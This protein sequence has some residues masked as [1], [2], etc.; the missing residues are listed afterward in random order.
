MKRHVLTTIELSHPFDPKIW[1]QYMVNAYYKYCLEK[2]VLPKIHQTAQP[3]YLELIGPISAVNEVKQKYELMSEIGE[4]R[5]LADN[6]ISDLNEQLPTSLNK[7]TKIASDYYN[8]MLS[9]CSDDQTL[10]CRLADRLFDEGYLV[11]MDYSDKPSANIESKTNKTDLIIICFTYSYSHNFHCMTAMTS[12][13]Q[14]GKKIIPIVLVKHALNQEDDW[15]Q[16]IV[17]EELFYE[18]FEQEIKFRLKEDLDVDYDKLLVELVRD[19]LL[20]CLIS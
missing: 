11:S 5:I 6:H 10:I 20:T 9:C 1:N 15:V 14:S 12:L 4:K 8:I 18:S 17:T 2:L 16:K 7:V 19:L 3:H 13:K